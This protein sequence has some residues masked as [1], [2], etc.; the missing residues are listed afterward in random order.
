M[1]VEIG[2]KYLLDASFLDNSEYSSAL[3]YTRPCHAEP[4]TLDV[5]ITGSN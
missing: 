2:C 1:M 5:V 4:A 3:E